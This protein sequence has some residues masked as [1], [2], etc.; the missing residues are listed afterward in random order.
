MDELDVL[1]LIERLIKDSCVLRARYKE[2]DSDYADTIDRGSLLSAIKKE[3]QDL[4][5]D[6]G[7]DDEDY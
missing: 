5:E 3:I 2:G 1:N 7:F 6:K 4:E